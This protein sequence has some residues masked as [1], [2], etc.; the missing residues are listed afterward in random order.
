MRVIAGELGGRLFESPR[1][2]RTH[3]M[4]EKVRGAIFNALGDIRGLKV[5]DAYAG[6]G[7]LS[8]EALS[9]GAQSAVVVEIDKQVCK[10]LTRNASSLDLNDKLQIVQAPIR[11][12]SNKKREAAFDLI[13]CD[14]PYDAVLGEEINMLTRHL[15]VGSILVLSWPVHV[16]IPALNSCELVGDKNYAGARIV[17][18]RRVR[19]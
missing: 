8:I 11:S 7:S 17:Y 18:Y 5:L 1:L 6:S 12:W 4:G 3:P 13:L 14:P 15:K 9:R 19:D 16:E 10:V 2:G